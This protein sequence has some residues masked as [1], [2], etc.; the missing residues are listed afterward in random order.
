MEWPIILLFRYFAVTR[1]EKNTIK[2]IRFGYYLIEVMI[3]F[4]SNGI[5]LSLFYK[6]IKNCIC[7]QVWPGITRGHAFYSFNI[8]MKLIDSTFSKGTNRVA[9]FFSFNFILLLWPSQNFSEIIS[10]Q[11]WSI[12]KDWKT[13]Y[14]IKTGSTEKFL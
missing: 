6:V 3:P 12:S 5:K 8:W 2:L 14:V 11:M 13:G 1:Q 10:M 7:K 9:L 4:V